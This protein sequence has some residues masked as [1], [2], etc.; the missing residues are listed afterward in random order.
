MA[1]TTHTMYIMITLLLLPVLL[2]AL[3]LQLAVAVL[4]VT[5][6]MLLA[7][8]NTTTHIATFQ[9]SV[10]TNT[11]PGRAKPHKNN[12]NSRMAT[13]I[14]NETYPHSHRRSAKN[15]SATFRRF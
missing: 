12:S 13:L 4:V 10:S 6:S 14:S 15:R 1:T 5:R 9:S 11:K 2:V 7:L 3:L 8:T